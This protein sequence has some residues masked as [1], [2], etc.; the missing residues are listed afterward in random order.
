MT[1]TKN[2]ILTAS[3]LAEDG[4]H[5]LLVGK[6]ADDHTKHLCL[7]TVPNEYFVTPFRRAHWERSSQTHNDN[8]VDNLGTVGALVLDRH[9]VATAYKSGSS[10]GFQYHRYRWLLCI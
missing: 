3:A 5:C 8:T 1:E 4:L 7:E 6:A 10:R 2:P 9:Q